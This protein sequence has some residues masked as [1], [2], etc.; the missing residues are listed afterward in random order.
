[1]PSDIIIFATKRAEIYDLIQR[2]KNF[3]VALTAFMEI[4]LF[5]FH[6]SPSFQYVFGAFAPFEPRPSETRKCRG[7]CERK[8]QSWLERR[9]RPKSHLPI[10]NIGG[11]M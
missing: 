9:E 8:T 10:G 7:F 1:M 4:K 5:D 11:K 6:F 2:Y 3:Y